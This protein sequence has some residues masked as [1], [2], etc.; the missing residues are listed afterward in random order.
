MIRVATD[1]LD[2][3]GSLAAGLED[4]A[5]VRA[6]IKSL[7]LG[8]IEQ[9]HDILETGMPQT[10]IQLIKIVLPLATKAL[11]A[12]Q[13][14]DDLGDL[15]EQMKELYGAVEKAIGGDDE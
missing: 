1:A 8:V 4:D 14:K 11:T 12:T 5:D 13:E 7:A 15:R 2:L 3:P 6:A 10:K 9:C